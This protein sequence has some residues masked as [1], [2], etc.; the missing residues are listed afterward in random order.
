MATTRGSPYP[1]RSHFEAGCATELTRMGIIYEYEPFDLEY[2]SKV[3][4]GECND[5][6][7]HDVEKIR[8][9]CPDFWVPRHSTVIES[10]GKFTSENRTKM[11]D[12]IA[13]HPDINVR[14]WFMY[15]NKLHKKSTVRYSDWCE[16]HRVT[17][18][19]GKEAPLW[20]DLK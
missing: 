8:W 18:H 3:R 16:K 4:G 14:M 1:F 6:G 19:I 13:A 10:K 9:Y 12:V 7:S 15:N 5:C 17:Y 2:F 20:N 11:L